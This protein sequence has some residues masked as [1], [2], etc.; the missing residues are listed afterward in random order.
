[1]STQ[2]Y[3]SGEVKYS[4]VFSCSGAADVGKIADQAARKLSQ[5][6]TASMCCIAAIGADIPEIIDTTRKADKILA[7]DGCPKDC[8]RIML[9]KAGFT[10]IK[11]LQLETLGMKKKESPLT[12]E[13][14][15]TVLK[16]ARATFNS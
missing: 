15:E 1:M 8:A 5:E 7:I 2:D 12:E 14:V 13:R 9:E 6:K 16:H 3:N 4:L 10:G 11:H